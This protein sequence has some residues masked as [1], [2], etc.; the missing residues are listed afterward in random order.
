MKAV[1]EEGDQEGASTVNGV[2]TVNAM[3]TVNASRMGADRSQ[4]AGPGSVA[5]MH[6]FPHHQ[7]PYLA[8]PDN[9]CSEGTRRAG[10]SA[11]RLQK[12][13]LQTVVLASWLSWCAIRRLM[14]G[15]LHRA[16][17][18]SLHRALASGCPP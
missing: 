7:R 12:P 9:F 11:A 8:F 1:S 14:W 6:G 15:G 2:Q 16:S 17:D 13:R 4:S 5:E 18:R 10:G 3:T